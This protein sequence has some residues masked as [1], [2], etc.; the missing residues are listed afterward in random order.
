[1]S[2]YYGPSVTKWVAALDHLL[3]PRPQEVASRCEADELRVATWNVWFA[4]YYQRE[5]FA[6]LLHEALSW[7]PDVLCLQEVTDTFH[8][9]M[10]QCRN[11]RWR[12]LETEEYTPS[13]DGY[14]V[15]LW[16]R[17]DAQL[18]R[19][20]TVELPTTQCRRCLVV[21]LRLPRRLE[22]SSWRVRVAS[23]H[24]ESNQPEASNAQLRA[25]QLRTILP[26][27]RT[28]PFEEGAAGGPDVLILAGNFNF[29]DTCAE[30]NSLISDDSLVVDAWLAARPGEPGFTEDTEVNAMMRQWQQGRQKQVRYDR[31]LL[32]GSS[33][34]QEERCSSLSVIPWAV[35]GVEVL[36]QK[37]LPGLEREEIWPSDHFGLFARL[38]PPDVA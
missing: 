9:A 17:A 24:L 38:L 22:E 6:A 20:W 10:R 35:A 19:C 15:A 2:S 27:L 7:E 5:R 33:E 1:M 25:A 13:L 29:C 37:P 18:L 12:L 14:D 21:D 31:I 11:L 34:E 8:E 4:E 16:V 26:G 36:G 23:V 28:E 3:P 30:E 32:L